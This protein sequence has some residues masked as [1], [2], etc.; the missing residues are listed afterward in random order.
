MELEV[1]FSLLRPAKF[2]GLRVTPKVM[3]LSRAYLSGSLHL[4]LSRIR[5]RSQPR[6]TPPQAPSPKKLT[7]VIKKSAARVA[8]SIFTNFHSPYALRRHFFLYHTAAA[9]SGAPKPPAPTLRYGS[10]GLPVHGGGAV[11]DNDD[12]R[13]RGGDGTDASPGR[14]P[15]VLRRGGQ[16]SG[17]RR[18]GAGCQRLVETPSGRGRGRCVPWWWW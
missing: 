15:A 3:R 8:A 5:H 6:I 1:P 4:S 17:G 14:P 16:H 7:A 10:G 9:G 11:D 12:G 13:K 18:D 2:R